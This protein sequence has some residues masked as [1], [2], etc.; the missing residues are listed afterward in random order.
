MAKAVSPARSE[1]GP[2]GL[3]DPYRCPSVTS[4]LRKAALTLTTTPNVLSPCR[5]APRCWK[6]PSSTPASTRKQHLFATQFGAGSDRQVRCFEAL[7]SA[8]ALRQPLLFGDVSRVKSRLPKSALI[9]LL[10]DKIGDYLD[11]PEVREKL[12]VH[13]SVGKFS[14][15]SNPVG[16]GFHLALDSTDQTWLYV[17]QL[18][19]RGVRVL[20]VSPLPLVLM[21]IWLTP[22]VCR[23]ARLDLQSYR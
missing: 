10:S 3:A 6:A 12:G 2:K 19:E 13:K 11:L 8:G 15:C 5:I 14:S 18:L 17:G 23:Y 7:H 21:L 22:I 20:N 16:A 9:R 4:S 1:D